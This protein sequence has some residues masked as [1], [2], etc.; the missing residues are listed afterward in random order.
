MVKQKIIENYFDSK[1]YTNQEIMKNIEETKKEFSEKQVD[2]N[3]SLNKF[4]V[5]VVTYY[6]KNKE[7]FLNKVFIKIKKRRKNKK[8]MLLQE[9][10]KTREDRKKEKIKERLEKY[11]GN[12]Y[13]KYKE[14][15]TYKPY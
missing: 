6:F 5:Y 3:I 1:T 11:S 13:G 7:N 9:G 15:K 14:T 12:V 2:I 8:I 4:G 10:R